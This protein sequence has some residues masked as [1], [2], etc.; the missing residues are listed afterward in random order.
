MFVGL[1]CLLH[2]FATLLFGDLTLFY[3]YSALLIGLGARRLRL[4]C[5]INGNDPLARRLIT[6]YFCL[7][8]QR[9]GLRRLLFG[10]L[11]LL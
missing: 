5:P 1:S 10:D 7:G 9:I 8:A 3:R 11:A 4:S 2:G 6:R